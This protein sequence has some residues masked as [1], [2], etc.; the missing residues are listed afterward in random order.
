MRI[1]LKTVEREEI[2][3]EFVLHVCMQIKVQIQG[4]MSSELVAV[5]GWCQNWRRFRLVNAVKKTILVNSCLI[6][7]ES[8]SANWLGCC[9]G[10]SRLGSNMLERWSADNFAFLASVCLFLLFCR[11]SRLLFFSFFELLVEY[12][13]LLDEHPFSI[14]ERLKTP[15]G[16]LNS[17]IYRFDMY[18]LWY[19]I[20]SS[21]S[22][23]L[24]K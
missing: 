23:L 18:F 5:Q 19:F 21:T 22:L 9:I 13:V 15:L 20:A 8:C 7:V 16:I 12:F 10:E 11:S 14:V 17:S 24:W 6:G 2:Q 4:R 1:L 3:E